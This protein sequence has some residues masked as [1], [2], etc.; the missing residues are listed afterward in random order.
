MQFIINKYT[1]QQAVDAFTKVYNEDAMDM[2]EHK[3][4]G[5]NFSNIYQVTAKFDDSSDWLSCAL[6]VQY[7]NGRASVCADGETLTGYKYVDFGTAL[8][9][10]MQLAETCDKQFYVD[11]KY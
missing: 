4:C 3:C 7:A 9:K 5:L 6:V 11:H 1:K 10:L 8:S 2:L